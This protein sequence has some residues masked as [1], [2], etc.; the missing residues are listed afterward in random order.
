MIASKKTQMDRVGSAEFAPRFAPTPWFV[1]LFAILLYAVFIPAAQ[2]SVCSETIV[3]LHNSAR[4]LTDNNP[5]EGPSAPQSIAAQ[6]RHQPTP[7]TVHNAE[8]TAESNFAAIL[9]RAEALDAA[10]KH[11]KC[12]QAVSDAQRM[13][14]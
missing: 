6:L 8:R 12:M 7:F 5:A 13:L 3:Q 9:A 1:G 14:E 2:A 10:G 4:L 11:M